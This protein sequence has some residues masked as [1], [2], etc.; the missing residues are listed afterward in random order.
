MPKTL[1]DWIDLPP[2]WLALAL[3]VTWGF[4]QVMPWGLFG[5]A[6]R[7]VGAGLVIIGLGLLAAA[8][9]QMLAA[10][11][12]VIPR[13]QPRTLVT[14]GL[15]AWSRNPIY[16]AD[17]LILSGAILWW[18]V[19]VAVPLVFGF[20]F[21]IQHRFILREEMVLRAAFGLQFTQWAARTGRWF[22]RTLR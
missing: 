10:R 20:M 15:F 18:D 22:G 4:D 21:L 7:F 1:T 9:A 12:T 3:G 5:P 2:V 17:A 14:G 8:V 16:L 19:P 11:T 13:G 6:G